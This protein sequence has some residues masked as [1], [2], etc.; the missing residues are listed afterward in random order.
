MAESNILALTFLVVIAVRAGSGFSE[1]SWYCHRLVPRLITYSVTPCTYPCLVV[2]RRVNPHIVVQN[3]PDGTPCMVQTGLHHRRVFG[4][5][6]NS[7]CTQDLFDKALKRKKR[8]ICLYTIG[9]II[10]LKKQRR[11]LKNKITELQEQLHRNS[12]SDRGISR[13]SGID[14]TRTD[15]SGI[16]NYAPSDG[17]DFGPGHVGTGF[18][19]SSNSGFPGTESGPSALIPSRSPGFGGSNSAAIGTGTFDDMPTGNHGA[20]PFGNGAIRPGEDMGPGQERI[21]GLESGGVDVD[22]ATG[23]GRDGGPGYEHRALRE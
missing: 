11:N 17:E 7:V 20:E 22:G 6:R 9:R 18:S 16:G 8:F 3:E 2:S 23:F 10:H 19:G 5:C 12:Y 15:G 14:D 4:K 1:R 13:G 21:G